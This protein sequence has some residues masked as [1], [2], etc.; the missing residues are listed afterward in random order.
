M[1]GSLIA[2]GLL[3]VVAGFAAQAQSPHPG[4]SRTDET[5]RI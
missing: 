2:G 1:Q 4:P 3:L 5:C